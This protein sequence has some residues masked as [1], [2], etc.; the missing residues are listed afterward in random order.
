MREV[1]LIDTSVLCHPL[2]VPGKGDRH[3][4][5]REEFVGLHRAGVTLIVPMTAVIETG[6]HVAQNGNGTLRRRTAMAFEN[7]ILKAL[8]NEMPLQLYPFDP[9]R[10][11]GLLANYTNWAVNEVGLGDQT[12]IDAWTDVQTKLPTCR[13]RIWSFDGDLGGYDTHP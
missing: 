1:V 3:A 6:N 11:E 2:N 8:R 4:E 10:L 7:L 13:V 12:I 5:V 9:A